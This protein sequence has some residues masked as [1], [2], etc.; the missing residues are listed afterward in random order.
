MSRPSGAGYDVVVEVDDEGDL[1]H[2]DLET[3]LDFQDFGHNDTPTGK[4]PQEQPRGFFSGGGSSSR[5]TGGDNGTTPTGK[6]YLWS[7]SFYAQFFNVDTNEV[8]RRCGAAI[9]PKSNFLDVLEGNP[10]LYG[11]VWIA[12]TVV[13]ML[14]LS[15][16][17]ASYFSKVKGT[18][19][20]FKYNFASLTGAAGLVYGY[21]AFVPAALWGV[22]KWYGSD[23]ANLLECLSL[24]GYAN[25]IWVPVSIASVSPIPILNWVFCAVGLGV[26][27][28][29]LFRNLYPVISGIDAQTSKIVLIVMLLLHGGYALAIKV[30]FFAHTSL[31]PLDT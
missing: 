13:L 15:S 20:H 31:K 2:T 30:L 9:F 28:M 29:F 14:F 19:D 24:Y 5:T 25:V 12:S 17:L 16:T 18:E 7:I 21:T 1:G 10:D 4:I 8:A 11:P 6:R 26:S 27:A 23:S 22:L 3:G